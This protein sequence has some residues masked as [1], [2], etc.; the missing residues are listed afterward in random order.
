MNIGKKIWLHTFK[1]YLGL[2]LFFYFK[3]IKVYN[4]KVLPKDKSVLILCNHQNALLDPLLIA[5]KSIRFIHFLARASVFKKSF[6]DTFLRSLQ[7][8]PVY[9]VR[10]GWNNL[11]KNH[12]IFE[13][14]SYLLGNNEG[15]LI[16]P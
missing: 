8:L 15:I 13:N 1:T 16:F 2:G 7:M 3:K 4:A 9:R 12:E 11:S 14:C 5:T 6:G 10:D